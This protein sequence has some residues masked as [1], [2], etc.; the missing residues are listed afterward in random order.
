MLI[1]D[2]TMKTLHLDGNFEKSM[3]EDDKLTIEGYASTPD[4]DADGDNILSSAWDLNRYLKN[5]IILFNHNKA[6]PMGIAVSVEPKPKGLYI[7]A[8]ISK[9][10]EHYSMVKEGILKT[11]SVG[12]RPREVK[13]KNDKSGG[14]LI[15]K[16]ELHEISVVTVPSNPEAIFSIKKSFESDE[17]FQ[18]FYKELSDVQ[19]KD[20][21]PKEKNFMDETQLAA[22]AASVADIVS[23]QMNEKAEA[24]RI[25][26]EKAA[27]EKAATEKA[28]AEKEALRVEMGKSSAELIAAEVEKRVSEQKA[29]F[30]SELNNAIKANREDMEKLF[31]S[32]RPSY[33]RG[34]G[35]SNWK[36]DMYSDVEK[37]FLLSLSSK[38][39]I[40]QTKFGREILEKVNSFSSA[41]VSSADFEQ[42]VSTNLERDIQLQLILA[43]MFREIAMTSASMILPI[44]PDAGYAEITAAQRASDPSGKGNLDVAGATYG[45]GAGIALTE[46]TFTTKKLI[47]K[48]W[49]ANE[50]EEDAILAILPIIK[51]SMVR[52]HAR[53]VENGFLVGN[54]ADGFYTSGGMNSLGSFATAGTKFTA[55]AGTFAATDMFTAADLLALRQKMGKYGVNP[56]DIVY[57]VSLDVYYN[58]LSDPEWKDVQLVGDKATKLNG[59]VGNIYGSKVVVSPE[60]KDKAA[61]KFCA[62]AVNTRNFVVPRLRGLT[63]EAQYMVEDQ[64]QVL[65]T[66]QRLNFDEI[67]AGAKSVWGLKY[68]AA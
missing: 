55:P 8:V 9:S 11:F 14:L 26:T 41:T 22:L 24:E 45:S 63:S 7:Q 67:I 10:S 30:D 15:S 19:N 31:N 12:F 35:V 13:P 68:K 2:T 48:A 4:I 58:L 53:A 3:D 43:P 47:S 23:K 21:D 59:E 62:F 25:A 20:S 17:A 27:A 56:N 34:T 66:S 32:R 39:S 64:A 1:K 44:Q 28:L 38:K 54:T 50:T 52:S 40:D 37:A 51:D 29:A 46:K 60:F 65:V 33:D 36:V 5:P 61:G 6:L 18:E 57:V 16:A 49:L 42:V